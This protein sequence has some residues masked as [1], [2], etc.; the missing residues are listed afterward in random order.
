VRELP[1]VGARGVGGAHV[2][3]HH[4][5]VP[6]PHMAWGS[7]WDGM[8]WVGWDGMGRFIEWMYVW[9]TRIDFL[10]TLDA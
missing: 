5:D 10:A 1:W 9:Y 6:A 7:G 2:L 4:V 3:V 8:G